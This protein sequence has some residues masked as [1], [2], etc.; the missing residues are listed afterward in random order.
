MGTSW[1]DIRRS[2]TWIVPLLAETR[3]APQ[4][5]SMRI[6][7]PVQVKVSCIRTP[8]EALDAVSYGVAAVG[9]ATALPTQQ[10]QLS[11]EEIL[12]ISSAVPDEVGTFL[13]TGER[14]VETIAASALSCG[15]NTVQL[16][17]SLPPGSY[18]D[19]RDRL[20][21]TAIVQTVHVVGEGAIDIALE[22]SARA[23][24]LVLDSHD[25]RP[26]FRWE[27]R[28]GSIHDWEIS[29][30]I[31]EAVSVPVILSGGLTARNVADAVR[32]V[33]PYGVE[34]CSGVRRDGE[35]DTHLLAAFLDRL[36]RVN[37]GA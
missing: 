4:L 25:P 30:R 21:D 23:D 10:Q 22:M 1:P 35:L 32:A 16:W 7:S 17:E 24:A 26:P 28:H 29:R 14:D 3:H 11:D 20:P 2:A 33:G 31:V 9:V 37:P 19:L 18:R 36:T 6:L 12:D 34:V 15:V 13:L 8:E 5:S 27:D